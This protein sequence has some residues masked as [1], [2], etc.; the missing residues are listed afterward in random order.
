MPE[1][2]HAGRGL[3]A[4]GGSCAAE[5]HFVYTGT[6]RTANELRTL[7]HITMFTTPLGD[8]A[9]QPV[10]PDPMDITAPLGQ[11]ARAYLHTNM[12]A[13]PPPGGWNAELDGPA[14]LDAALGHGRLRCAAAVRGSWHR[15]RG[16][17]RSRR[18]PVELRGWWRARTAAMRT[19]CRQWRRTSLIAGVA[20]LQQ[21][22]NGSHH[23]P[24][25]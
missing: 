1:L 7:D 14:L 3:R 15:R 9:N 19:A 24:M 10:M 11:R 6:G 2:P 17:H 25:N 16:A 18:Q 13:M 8:P 5:P 21:W 22:I 12:L 23:V 20:L 4:R